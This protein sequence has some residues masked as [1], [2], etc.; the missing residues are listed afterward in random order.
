MKKRG[1]GGYRYKGEFP[2]FDYISLEDVVKTGIYIIKHLLYNPD[3][4]V[5]VGSALAYKPNSIRSG[6]RLRWCRHLQDLKDNKHHSQYLQNVCNKYGIEN[7][8]FDILQ[9]C[10]EKGIHKI[11]TDWIAKLNAYTKGYNGTKEGGNCTGFKMYETVV[12]KRRKKLARYDLDGNFI[13]IWKDRRHVKEILG[14][15]FNQQ[16]I[17]STNYSAG[18]YMWTY[19]TINNPLKIE[20]YRDLS[21]TQVLCYDLEGNFI[22]LY[23]RMIDATN[24]MNIPGGNISKATRGI[25]SR[26]GIACGY[27]WRLYTE[28]YPIKIEPWIPKTGFQKRMVSTN[29]VT[30][31]IKI[32][33]SLRKLAEELKISRSQVTK[34]RKEGITLI[35]M[36][37][38]P[39]HKFRIEFYDLPVR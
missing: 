35:K 12:D 27:Q 29:L 25:S 16:A 9:F 39:Y 30:G 8:R 10:G 24:E 33:L 20:S 14:I 34:N 28:N 37:K 26:N 6:F 32:H 19:S 13:D 21:T 7:L 2:Q 5:Y 23:K 3:N 4:I 31:E 38:K 22:K 36:Q 1:R 17:G 15:D 11:E 18:S